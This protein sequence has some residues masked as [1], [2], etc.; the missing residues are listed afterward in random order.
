MAGAA[1]AAYLATL[2]RGV[3]GGDSGEL[4]ASAVTGGVAHPPGYP[5]FLLLARA[6][7][8]IPVGSVAARVNALSAV[9]DAAAAGLLT[10]A[11]ARLSKSAGA[12][13]LAGGLF[14]F[15]TRVWT[16][17]TVA[18]VFALNN[19][20][21][22]ALVT[23]LSVA[24]PR[25]STRHV[26]IGSALLGLG[27]ANHH[28]SIFVSVPIVAW[29]LFAAWR[30]GLRPLPIL[31]AAA[32]GVL[33]GLLPYA[34]LPLAAAGRATVSWGDTAS[35][36]GFVRHV[37]RAEYGTF[38]LASTHV[39][40]ATSAVDH[41][42]AYAR[43]VVTQSLWL[44]AP[45]ALVG[46]GAGLVDRRL[47]GPVAACLVG[48]VAYLIV[49]NALSNLPLGVPLLFEVQARFWQTPNLIVFVLTGIGFATAA[50]WLPRGP[51]AV[52]ATATIA[53]AI[54]VVQVYLN[55]SSMDESRMRWVD[56]YGRSVLAAAPPGALILTRG[57]LTTN[58]IH[59]L[60]YAEGVRPDVRIVDQEILSLPWGPPR[61][62]RLLP[63]VRFPA[64][65]YDPRR[66]DGFSMKQLFDANVDRFPV[67][68]CGGVKE[69]DH[70]VS[71]TAYRLLPRGSCAEV[72]RA[73]SPLAV[74]AWLARNRPLLPDVSAL[75]RAPLRVGS[76]E[77][78][79]RT[80]AWA[81]WHAPAYF[82]MM[83]AECGLAPA[84]RFA[85]FVT[86]ADEITRLGPNPAAYVYK[87][88][89]YALGQL[90]PTQPDVRDQLVVAMQEYLRRG[91]RDDPDLPVIRENL[92][93]LGA[94][95]AD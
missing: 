44:G 82:V 95:V 79:V 32:A 89:A 7:A 85:R 55:W 70:S 16:N 73:G 81:A 37:T 84:E 48:L 90:F 27:I 72:T 13:V 66:S 86:M 47:R 38:Q 19:L 28:T 71:A 14:A 80:D 8:A 2:Q 21:L 74:D 57:D 17:A 60:R 69:G 52:S 4:I 9:C 49:F 76:W 18:E 25:P 53:V 75:A 24:G 12:G 56:A 92:V 54:A 93:K 59:Y 34:Y 87:N 63:D 36:A 58:T 65:V 20:L 64:A 78:V 61:Y 94:R 29:L 40:G 42:L 3:P 67:L 46:A 88:L 35:L 39:G 50:A 31:R 11:V 41:V 15:S 33:L 68:V 10:F 26:G 43:D 91:P 23:T 83:C 77:E 1:L 5:L 62:A 30:P 45:L 6:A 22:A 51:A